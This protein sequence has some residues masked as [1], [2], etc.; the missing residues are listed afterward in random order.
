MRVFIG[1]AL[2]ALCACS[3]RADERPADP[4]EIASEYMQQREG[5]SRP[6]ISRRPIVHDRGTYWTVEYELDP[7]WIGGA[8]KLVIDKRTRRVVRE[9]G[10]Q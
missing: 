9:F 2:A 1:L 10:E 5:G 4:V 3:Q 7:G 8:P 6:G